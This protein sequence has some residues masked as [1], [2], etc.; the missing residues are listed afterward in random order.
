MG[1]CWLLASEDSNSIFV[2]A[3]HALRLQCF[4]LKFNPYRV[5]VYRGIVFSSEI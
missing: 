3:G 1:S 2:G 5:V 4:F